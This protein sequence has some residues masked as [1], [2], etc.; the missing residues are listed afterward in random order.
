MCACVRERERGERA[1]LSRK[2]ETTRAF[3]REEMKEFAVRTPDGV[4]LRCYDF[5]TTKN[6]VHEDGVLLLHCNGM[7]CL[8]Y[9][10]L[11]DH[12]TRRDARV[13][14]YDQ[15]GHGKSRFRD[16]A[17]ARV[18]DDDVDLSW[19]TFARDAELV[20]ESVIEKD[21]KEGC[22]ANGTKK[23]HAVGHSLGGF[24]SLWLEAT[25][26]GTFQSILAYEPIFA[27]ERSTY[28]QMRAYAE[29][30]GSLQANA[31]KRKRT[32]KSFEEAFTSYRKGI[33]GKVMD[34]RSLR[35]YVYD[36]GF[37]KDSGGV[38]LTC[39]PEIEARIYEN[40]EEDLN[41][42]KFIEERIDTSNCPV[43]IAIGGA[44]KKTYA[45]GVGKVV[46]ERIRGARTLEFGLLGHFGPLSAPEAFGS[47]VEQKLLGIHPKYTDEGSCY[48]IERSRL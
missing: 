20:L 31:R 40:G 13:V 5:N 48:G 8:S 32:F 43:T 1:P 33:L 2:D 29:P 7:N 27:L 17:T 41:A 36:G 18:D 42:L 26:P 21:R 9:R 45:Y 3:R 4:T 15:R 12:L 39:D 6:G 28:P 30:D 16:D 35:G 47:A 14:T 23:W 44:T 19:K 38:V 34:E 22:D 24:A 37:K 10:A 25:K 46:A 11:I